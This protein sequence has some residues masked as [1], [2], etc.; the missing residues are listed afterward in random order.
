MAARILHIIL[1]ISVFFSTTGLIVIQHYCHKELKKIGFFVE[2]DGCSDSMVSDDLCCQIKVPKNCCT[3]LNG[4]EKNNN[5]CDTK[6]AYY[7]VDQEL[8]AL[9]EEQSEIGKLNIS[10]SNTSHSFSENILPEFQKYPFQNYQTP[11]IVYDF[12]VLFQSFLC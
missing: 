11:L 10:N 4:Q 12:S 8:K 9:S 2:P 7:K 3:I 6:T 5:C 1:A